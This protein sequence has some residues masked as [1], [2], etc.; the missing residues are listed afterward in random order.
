MKKGKKQCPFEPAK[1]RFICQEMIVE[2]KGGIDLP[3]S[4]KQ[5]RMVVLSSALDGVKEGDQLVI[6][7]SSVFMIEH[8]EEKYYVLGEKDYCAKWVK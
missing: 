2:S 5:K 8:E 1:N 6:E 3:E 7:A 4:L